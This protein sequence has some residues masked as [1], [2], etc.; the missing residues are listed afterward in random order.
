MKALLPVRPWC[1]ICITGRI[2]Q[3]LPSDACYLQVFYAPHIVSMSSILGTRFHP[4]RYILDGNHISSN[5]FYSSS[6]AQVRLCMPALDLT[7]GCSPLTLPTEAQM[8]TV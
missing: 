2:A 4:I 8:A 6:I 7:P 3:V 1:C 5:V